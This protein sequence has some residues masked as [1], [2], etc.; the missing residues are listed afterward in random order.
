MNA[1]PALKQKIKEIIKHHFSD[2]TVDVSDGYG[3][4][5]HVVVVSRKFDDLSE[6]EK[7]E[8]LWNIID[9]SDLSDEQKVKISMILPMSP[10]E[11]K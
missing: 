3:G 8:L 9:Q 11:L 5:I 10:A 7:Q 6:K 4:N 2:D 1:D